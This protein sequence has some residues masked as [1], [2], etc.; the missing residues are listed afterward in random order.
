MC[1]LPSCR[2]RHAVLRELRGRHPGLGAAFARGA[3][4]FAADAYR[5]DA[6]TPRP[7]RRLRRCGPDTPCPTRRTRHL[8]CATPPTPAGCDSGAAL[9]VVVAAVVAVSW[10]ATPPPPARSP[11]PPDCGRPPAGPSA[12]PPRACRRAA[13]TR[14]PAPPPG[15]PVHGRRFSS[16]DGAFSVGYPDGAEL[17]PNVTGLVLGDGNNMAW[18]FGESA[19]DLTPRQIAQTL[20][21]DNWPGATMTYQIPNAMVGYAPGYGEIDD[22]YPVSGFGSARH[23]RVLVMVAEKNGLALIA[24]ARG[25]YLR[26]RVT[27]RLVSVSQSRSRGSATWSTASPGKEIHPAD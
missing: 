23:L 11:C 7:Q 15:P 14:S 13:P 4:P 18:V 20:V 10:L 3:A 8:R 2:S 21:Q 19:A 27:T 5:H 25:P 16:P 1:A 24:L 6:W 17:A 9:V 22:Y 26:T 12:G